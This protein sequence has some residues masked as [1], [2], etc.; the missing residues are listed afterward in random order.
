MFRALANRQSRDER[1][2]KLVALTK[3]ANAQNVSP[4]IFYAGQITLSTPLIN[5]TFMSK[6][7]SLENFQ[8]MPVYLQVMVIFL[9]PVRTQD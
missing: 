6:V 3:G 1:I 4:P 7:R 5:K 2:T 8:E 9:F